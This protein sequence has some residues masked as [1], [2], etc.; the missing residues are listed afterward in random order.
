MTSQLLPLTQ[1]ALRVARQAPHV[2]RHTSHVARRTSHITRHTSHVTRHT[3]YVTHNTYHATLYIPLSSHS[4]REI[5]SLQM[6]LSSTIMQ[7]SAAAAAAAANVSKPSS[8]ST[9]SFSRASAEFDVE[10]HQKLKVAAFFRVSRVTCAATPN[11]IL[12][13]PI[14]LDFSISSAQSAYLAYLS[15]GRSC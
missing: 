12:D 1:A 6:A 13:F 8:A 11:S 3:L 14:S 5:A 2:T 4:F 15:A 7:S 10:L 9:D